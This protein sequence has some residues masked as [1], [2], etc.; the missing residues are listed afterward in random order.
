MAAFMGFGSTCFSE[1]LKVAA[2]SFIK[3]PCYFFPEKFLFKES[4][5]KARTFIL[6]SMMKENSIIAFIMLSW[7]IFTPALSKNFSSPTKL[8]DFDFFNL[9]PWGGVV[10]TSP[11]FSGNI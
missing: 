11:I 5:K 10:F 3:Q 7:I 4:P 2:A 6:T 1:R 8:K 9:I